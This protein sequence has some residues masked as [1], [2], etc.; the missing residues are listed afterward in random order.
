MWITEGDISKK[1]V[2]SGDVGNVNQPIIKDPQIGQEADYLVIESTYGDRVHGEVR[3]D[4]VGE[5]TRDFKGDIQK[6]RECG[7][8]FLCGWT[9]AGDFVLYP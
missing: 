4:Y 2:F 1:I 8:S 6:R 9:Y 7:D 5:F 3:P